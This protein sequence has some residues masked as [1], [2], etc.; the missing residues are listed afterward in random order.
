MHYLSLPIAFLV[1]F[2]MAATLPATTNTPLYYP[3]VPVTF[4]GA[5]DSSYYMSVEANSKPV[6]TNNDLS[7]S[8]ISMEGRASFTC[9]AYGKDGSVTHLVANQV[10]TYAPVMRPP[11]IHQ[12]EN[13]PEFAS[14]SPSPASHLLLT[15]QIKQNVPVGPPQAQVSVACSAPPL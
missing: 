4:K 8:S 6:L 1:G 10:S 13:E 3:W 2:G 14:L 5:G 15:L 11:P 9:T 12:W 7:V